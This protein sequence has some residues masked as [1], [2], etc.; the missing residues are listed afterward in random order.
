MIRINPSPKLA[1]KHAKAVSSRIRKSYN[2]GEI[3]EL[4]Q[5]LGAKSI[6]DFITADITRLWSWVHE[7]SDKLHFKQFKEI[8][9]RY[10]SNGANKFVDGDYNA[11]SFLENLEIKVCPY[12]DD[13]YLDTF[14][15]CEK[16]RRTSE[17]DHFF[18]KSKYPALAMCFYNLI[19]SGQNCNGLKLEQELG[20]SPYESQIEDMTYL[21]PDP[22]LPVGIL[23][24]TIPP[25]D[26]KVSFHPQ[27]GMTKNV[28]ILGLEQRYERHAPE[29]HRILSNLQIYSTEKIQELVSQGYGTRNEI[30]SS[31]FGPQDP[32][33]KKNTLRQKMLR[34]LTGY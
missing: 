15:I 13:E 20:M 14:K 23:L 7:C 31:I 2:E 24:E 28:D 17:V 22:D 8:Y 11:Y 33:E 3:L 27:N 4:I 9:S 12:C 29:V 10:F 32:A 26:C 1:L 18:P 5:P 21:Y 6:E 34:D 19:P 16:Q 30:I 25:N